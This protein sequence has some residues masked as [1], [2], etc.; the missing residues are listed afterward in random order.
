MHIMC[1]VLGLITKTEIKGLNYFPDYSGITNKQEERLLD[2]QEQNNV[3]N[4]PL[5]NQR[6]KSAQDE[7]MYFQL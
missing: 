2:N 1:E 3:G 4:D 5:E 7:L 6:N